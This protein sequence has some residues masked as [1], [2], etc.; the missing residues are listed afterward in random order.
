MPPDTL[1]RLPALVL[2]TLLALAP[3]VS[4]QAPATGA[5]PPTAAE[6]APR[7]PADRTTRHEIAL[8]D[9]SLAFDAT[10][11]VVTL[12]APDGREEADI[13]YVAY[14]LDAPDA[15]A[16]PVT[17]AV[18]GGPGAASA[19]LHIGAMGPWLL[20]FEGETIVPSQS[21][22]LLANPDTWLDFTDLVFVDPVG[23]GFSRLVDP[24]DRLRDRYL[25]IDGD[26]EAM[27]DFI[28]RWLTEN[29][30][31]GSP[32]VFV[33]ESY[34][35]FRAPLVAESLQ[36]DHGVGLDAI[37]LLSP[38]LDFG[39]WQQPDHAPL[40]LAS[41]LP[42]LA[43]TRMEA[44]GSFSEAGI[45]AAESYAAGAYV[46]DMLKGV[47]D[48]AAVDRVVERVT[49]LTGLDRD[50]VARVD[51]RV[52]GPLFAR[53]VRRDERRR[54][55]VYDAT[56]ASAGPGARGDPVLDAL[57]APLTGGMIGLYRDRLDWLPERRYQ[58]LNRDV[59]RYWDWGGGRGQPEVV[60]AL[61]QVLSLDPEFRVLVAH[62]YTDL[63]TP[64]FG[65]ALILR[66]IRAA[67]PEG[68]V[69]LQTYRGGHMF[70]I[71]DDSRRQFRDDARTLYDGRTG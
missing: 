71:R 11:G 53:E 34:G 63:V 40:P 52:D 3:P 48:P 20:P 55:S 42:S 16:R 28:T 70:Y 59:S 6:A 23:T 51:G 67:G 30:R 47:T 18:N 8:A 12:T 43:A 26:V 50:V 10:A 1:P 37:A 64:Y 60:G 68:R 58:L 31:I 19:Y 13:A 41:L 38:V 36:E 61:E 44:A 2:A 17:F 54:A 29:G 69:Q 25:S 33:G 35:G 56:M 24:D 32:K 49:A 7:L 39:W 4:A 22:A 27:A 46:T 5:V 9:R 57:T 14:V 15:A 66:Q 62:G 65:S 21:V 45:A